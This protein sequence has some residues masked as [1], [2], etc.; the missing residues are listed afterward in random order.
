MSDLLKVS[1]LSLSKG[2]EI[3]KKVSFALSSGDFLLILGPSGCGKSSLL[4]CLNRL[5]TIS[6]GEVFLN[7][8]NTRTMDTMELRRRVGMVFQT[9]ALLPGSVKENISLSLRLR[10]QTLSNE[11]CESLIQN[12]GL[13]LDYLD[14]PVEN[15]S[16]G[17]QQRVALAQTLA[18]H[19][20]VLMLDEPTSALD[21]TAVS[22]IERLIQSINREMKSAILWVTHDVTQ[23]VRF[24]APT[25]ILVDGEIVAEGNIRELM[26][27]GQNEMLERFF[28]GTLNHDPEEKQQGDTDGK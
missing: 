12:V 23:A 17:E 26:A 13:S 21:P 5:E 11:D 3:L 4:R 25:L 18:N 19:P 14:R 28:K 24:N 10:K 20:Q 1:N 9:P 7:G 2:K 16:I 22:T 6:N 8:Q 15:L 27:S